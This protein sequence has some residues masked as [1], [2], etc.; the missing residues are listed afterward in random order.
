MTTNKTPVAK[1]AKVAKAKAV[2]PTKVVE[3]IPSSVAAAAV[4]LGESMQGVSNAEHTASESKVALV[5]I[6]AADIEGLGESTKVTRKAIRAALV[7]E[8][9]KAYDNAKSISA[10]AS[11]IEKV[12]VYLSFEAYET[13]REAYQALKGEGAPSVDNLAKLIRQESKGGAPTSSDAIGSSSD[14]AQ[15]L[16]A[17]KPASGLTGCMKAITNEDIEAATASDVAAFKSIIHRK[18]L[19]K[20]LA[21]LFAS[22]SNEERAEFGAL[23]ARVKAA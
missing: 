9:T 5:E 18:E 17:S 12:A 3:V 4:S 2:T 21:A 22:M 20:T 1:V 15:K 13:V 7:I 16:A 10:S 11:T 8:M 6:M 23:I 14:N 19:P